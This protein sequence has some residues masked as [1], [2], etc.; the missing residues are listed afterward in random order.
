MI[1]RR[2]L[3]SKALQCLYAY[4]KSKEANYNLALDYIN[5][6]F[7]PDLNSMEPVDKSVLNTKKRESLKTFQYN[8]KHKRDYFY[9]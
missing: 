8:F 3:R 6:Q 2:I 9:I 7:L 1:N 5:N 4:Y